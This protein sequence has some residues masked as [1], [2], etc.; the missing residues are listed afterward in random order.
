MIRYE[1]V[2]PSVQLVERCMNILENAGI[3]NLPELPKFNQR[4]LI[5]NDP[6]TGIAISLVSQ[7]NRKGYFM[8]RQELQNGVSS[9]HHS[10]VFQY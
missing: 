7:G 9:P 6:K 8:L 1:I 10:A 4:Q 2:D 3:H 5:W